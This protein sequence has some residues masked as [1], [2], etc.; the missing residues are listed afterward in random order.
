MATAKMA[1][2]DLTSILAYNLDRHLMVPL[3]EFLSMQDIYDQKELLKTRLEFLN[4]TNMV[5]FSIGVWQQLHETEDVP[6]DLGKRREEVLEEIKALQED[7][8]KMSFLWED[9]EVL[10]HMRQDMQ[11]NM[12][13]LKEKYNFD[14]S[15]LE[16]VY[17]YAKILYESGNYEAAAAYLYDYRILSQDHDKSFSALWGKFACEIL[18]QNWDSALEEMQRLKEAIE[19]K[20]YNN[21]LEQ[22]QQRTWLIHWGLFVFFNHPKGKEEF[23]QLCFTPAYMNTIQTNC[24][25]ILRYLTAAVILSRGRRQASKDLKDLVEVIK[26]E[27]YTYRD[28][29]TELVECLHVNYD[30]DA[31]QNKM[32]ECNELLSNDFFLVAVKDELIDMA[33]L[34]IF[35][36]YCSIHQV[37]DINMLAEKLDMDAGEA[38]RWIVNLIRNARLDAKIDSSKHQVIMGMQY[39]SIYHQVVEKAKDL[40]YRGNVLN[41]NLEQRQDQIRENPQLARSFMSLF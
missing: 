28:P 5:D 9:P 7:S 6:E 12:Q 20:S 21:P 18:M 34:D 11:Y 4:K 25:H 1:Q 2:Y 16:T 30:F 35:E 3:L 40:Q 31:A 15:T 19:N 33:R 27:A 36:T 10:Q 41:K 8:Q 22:L 38:E 26:Q 37:I 13:Y 39:T 23:I 29:V 14:P 32:R 17:R 24:T